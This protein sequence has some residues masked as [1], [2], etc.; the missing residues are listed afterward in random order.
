MLGGKALGKV[1]GNKLGKLD[2]CAHAREVRL[3]ALGETLPIQF[4]TPTQQPT[5]A[6]LGGKGGRRR[7]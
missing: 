5:V 6:L 4:K 1:K 2:S 7:T 3:H